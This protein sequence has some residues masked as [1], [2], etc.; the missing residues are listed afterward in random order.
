VQAVYG[1]RFA[2]SLGSGPRSAFLAEG[3]E[4]TVYRGVRLWTENTS[5]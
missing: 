5:R 2:E 4:V 3:S 1:A